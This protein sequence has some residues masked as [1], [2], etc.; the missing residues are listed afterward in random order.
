MATL[1]NNIELAISGSL[2]LDQIVS[3]KNRYKGDYTKRVFKKY[4]EGK[5]K[6]ESSPS[7][8]SAGIFIFTKMDYLK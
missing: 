6:F 3:D 5:W 2:T 8:I 4:I 7:L 1:A